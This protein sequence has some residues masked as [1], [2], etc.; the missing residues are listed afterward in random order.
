MTGKPLTGLTRLG[1]YYQTF[2]RGSVPAWAFAVVFLA[3]LFAAYYA[4]THRPVRKAI[5]HFV[6]DS[7]NC[8]WKVQNNG[9]M[10]LGIGGHFTYDG[11]DNLIVLKAYLE[12]SDSR[13][14]MI[15]RVTPRSFSSVPRLGGNP[16]SQRST[17]VLSRTV[18]EIFITLLD[19]T[20]ILGTPG[21]SLRTRLIL[22]DKFN[23]D[24]P[25]E[26]MVELEYR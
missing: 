20:P 2:I 16:N 3:F 9:T 23:R 8:I 26:P 1:A 25:V 11:P 6:P 21:K 22:R 19:V 7:P 18:T 5:V 13:Q 10:R 24:F 14:K 4:Y 17:F 15:A 12:G